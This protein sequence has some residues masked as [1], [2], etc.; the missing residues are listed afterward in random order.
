MEL[1]GPEK[2]QEAI[3]KIK[4]CDSFFLKTAAKRV[5][6]AGMAGEAGGCARVQHKLQ[7]VKARERLGVPCR[8]LGCRPPIGRVFCSKP[9]PASPSLLPCS[10][11]PDLVLVDY[12]LPSVLNDNALFY[13]E[14]AEL[15]GCSGCEHVGSLCRRLA[16]SAWRWRSGHVC[17]AGQLVRCLLGSAAG[18]GD[19]W[20]AWGEATWVI[21]T[22]C[23]HFTLPQV[24][25]SCHL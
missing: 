6:R 25:T 18:A 5:G 13:C 14:P 4:R 23:R 10:E 8:A 12:T 21:L 17:W 1:V 7:A 2:R 9:P 20:E 24:P 16:G 15:A 19:A 22:A 3:E 11:Y